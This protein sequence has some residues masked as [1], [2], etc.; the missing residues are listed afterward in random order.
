MPTGGQELSE[1]QARQLLT[2]IG[3]RTETL[4]ERLQQIYVAP[5]GPP[6]EDW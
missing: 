5:G 1:E 4:Q 3:R 6:A 2:A